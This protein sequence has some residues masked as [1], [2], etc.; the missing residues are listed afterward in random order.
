MNEKFLFTFIIYQAERKMF[1]FNFIQIL[2]LLLFFFGW[3]VLNRCYVIE[4]KDFMARS[5][6]A[7]MRSDS[8]A[9]EL[10]RQRVRKSVLV[11]VMGIFISLWG[12][13]MFFGFAS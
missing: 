11:S 2:G 12:M 9:R 3:V 7:R 1:S 10:T 4:L 8:R 6:P 13:A 5:L